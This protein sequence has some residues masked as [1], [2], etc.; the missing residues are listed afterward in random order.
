MN[1]LRSPALGVNPRV[2]QM[3][4]GQKREGHLPAGLRPVAV[5]PHRK[6]AKAGTIAVASC[7]VIWTCDGPVQNA[8]P[9]CP[10]VRFWHS[11]SA[12]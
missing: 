9:S 10:W 1:L 7:A 12:N 2:R 6:T 5:Y 11:A 4:W 8:P 3:K